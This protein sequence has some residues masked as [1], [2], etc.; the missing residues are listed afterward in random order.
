MVVKWEEMLAAGPV[1]TIGYVAPED[2]INTTDM[3]AVSYLEDPQYQCEQLAKVWGATPYQIAT[4]FV[5]EDKF[6]K[7]RPG[8]IESQVISG[9]DLVFESV[10]NQTLAHDW[11]LFAF[12]SDVC[13]M[14]PTPKSHTDGVIECACMLMEVWDKIKGSTVPSI[15]LITLVRLHRSYRKHL[16][17]A[18]HHCRGQKDYSLTHNGAAAEMYKRFLLGHLTI[19]DIEWI[20]EQ[21]YLTD[22]DATVD[23]CDENEAAIGG[24]RVAIKNILGA[25]MS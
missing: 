23:Y 5:V 24:T 19:D 2:R 7:L 22:I 1:N 13:Y 6:Y 12:F 17:F 15:S 21:L 18:G 11:E 25:V 3:K 20:G 10:I 9:A 8:Q 14:S 4:A 16:W